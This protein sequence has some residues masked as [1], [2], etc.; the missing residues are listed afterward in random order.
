MNCV[1]SIKTEGTSFPNSTFNAIMLLLSLSRDKYFLI[2]LK[3]MQELFL[4]YS[5]FIRRN[6]LNMKVRDKMTQTLLN[7]G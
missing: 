4:T 5:K 7:A 1:S 6:Y 3:F 2:E